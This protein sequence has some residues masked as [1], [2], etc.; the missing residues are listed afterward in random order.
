MGG[1]A[2]EQLWGHRGS[3]GQDRVDVVPPV[4]MDALAPWPLRAAGTGCGSEWRGLG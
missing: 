4:V 3:P 1:E 2:A